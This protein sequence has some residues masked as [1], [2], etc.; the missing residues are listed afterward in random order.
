MIA[1]VYDLGGTNFKWEIHSKGQLISKG[2][3][4]ILNSSKEMNKKIWP[5]Y[6]D[7]YIKNIDILPIRQY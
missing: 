2:L 5:N 7:T 3:F 6:S 4:S 1:K